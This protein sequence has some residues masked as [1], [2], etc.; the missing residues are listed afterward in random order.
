MFKKHFMKLFVVITL[1][2]S[3][4]NLPNQKDINVSALE[5]EE[6][7]VWI[8][9]DGLS[10]QLY[11]E[12][13]VKD[14]QLPNFELLMNQGSRLTEVKIDRPGYAGAQAATLT[15]HTPHSNGVNMRHF[16]QNTKKY[17]NDDLNLKNKSM[18]N[19]FEEYS[20]QSVLGI[21]WRV[22]ANRLT[23]PKYDVIPLPQNSSK[24]TYIDFPSGDANLVSM[25][26]VSKSYIDS[27]TE[28]KIPGILSAY[29]N[30]LV[31]TAWNGTA[32]Y[33]M[34]EEAMIKIDAELGKMIE[35]SKAAG[36]FDNTT[37]II[38]G[39][40]DVYFGLQKIDHDTFTG[41]LAE[42]TQL[43]V[44]TI[45]NDNFKSDIGIIKQFRHGY[46]QLYFNE[47]LSQENKDKIVEILNN[48]ETR[49]GK[50]LNKAV[51]PQEISMPE[52]VGDLVLWPETGKS[53]VSASNLNLRTDDLNNPYAFTLISGS[54]APLNK[55]LAN[56]NRSLVDILPNTLEWL[57]IAHNEEF[58]GEV[59]TFKSK[60]LTKPI[61]VLSDMETENK[62][63]YNEILTLSGGVT[64]E[65]VITINDVMVDLDENFKFSHNIKLKLGKNNITVKASNQKGTD[66]K[67]IEVTY[68]TIEASSDD[69][70]VVYIN[71]D[72]FAKHYLDIA[73]KDG[74]NVDT[75]KMIMKEGVSYENAYT[76]IPSI[77]N[78]MQPIIVSG[79]TPK[80][81]DNHYRY[82]DKDLKK[83]VQE[84]PARLNRAENIAQALERQN[85]ELISINKFVFEDFGAYANDPKHLYISVPG[86]S[87][88]DRFDYASEF[89]RTLNASGNQ[90]DKLP[91]FIAMYM[92]DLDGLGHNE[93]ILHGFPVSETEADRM[94]K[95]LIGLEML[96]A[97]LGEFIA[98]AKETGHYDKMS[99]ILTTDHGMSAYGQQ[100]VDGEKYLSSLPDLIQSIELM[101]FKVESLLA[102]EELQ[103]E[104]TDVVIISV[105]LQAQISY[106]NF[107][108]Q[109][110]ASA[111]DKII[112]GLKDKPYFGDFL[113]WK[114]LEKDGVKRGF[115][116]LLVSP[117]VPYNFKTGNPLSLRKARG[118]HDSLD[119]TS[120][121]VPLLMWGNKIKQNVKVNEK[122]YTTSV[123]PTISVLLNKGLPLDANAKILYD[124]LLMDPP[125]LKSLTVP[126]ENG[127]KLERDSEYFEIE[128][129]SSKDA[130][131]NLQVNGILLREVF[132]P[133][134]NGQKELKQINLNLKAGDKFELLIPNINEDN[135]EINSNI[136]YIV[137]NGEPVI[138]E[139][140][141]PPIVDEGIKPPAVNEETTPPKE[142]ELIPPITDNDITP[143]IVGEVITPPV[144]EEGI[145]PPLV[146][147]K[148]DSLVV[149]PEKTPASKEDLI[150]KLPVEEEIKNTESEKL[151]Q[152]GIASKQSKMILAYGSLVLG[153]ILV[154]R[155]KTYK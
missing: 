27:I 70:T 122:V 54:K 154:R 10:D 5:K 14:T 76:S 75:F 81:T 133:N 113:T 6:R 2:L 29:T 98:V 155:K 77:T 107:T 63:V 8:A 72:G 123:A 62:I 48:K 94:E 47:N 59:W 100:E 84:A 130:I 26:S 91:R 51:K 125:K 40:S 87:G 11:N 112:K 21:G 33:Q 124:E 90:F 118:Q 102:N 60:E 44:Q 22:G 148:N 30:D 132:F 12:F 134:T 88:L 52:A 139:E 79:T 153:M 53:F 1:L 138:D 69:N 28:N 128:Y 141:V 25:T 67:S 137:D 4:F 115:A 78:A 49:T 56:A 149:V 45:S 61:L 106:P 34:L 17:I 103:H 80:Y 116:D 145:I 32:T 89:L 57:G 99:F 86:G 126:Y 41:L 120:Q 65:A 74:R 140:V 50:L 109:E 152:T 19:I 117:K 111:N 119:I 144:V 15:G 93:K 114:E 150:T 95:T 66:S 85:T 146:E 101:G 71:W 58:E 92:D 147:D 46:G 64:D 131:L 18:F 23:A 108:D 38:H 129:T 36:E 110:I 39:L 127:F 43:S 105:G 96:D 121:R 20:D 142:E 73:I 16:N 97:K 143:P 3:L 136:Q 151:P 135:F 9:I 82:F 24:L 31:Q 55:D 37:W 35:A 13:M 7:I 42:D 83:A 104:D 68:N